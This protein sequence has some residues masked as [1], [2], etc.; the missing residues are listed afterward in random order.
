MQVK[1]IRSSKDTYWYANKIG[2][3]FDVESVGCFSYT[4]LPDCDRSIDKV[5]CVVIEGTD[6]TD[7]EEKS[8]AYVKVIGK[9]Y[10]SYIDSNH[11][12]DWLQD[13][14]DGRRG[15]IY[16]EGEATVVI[17]KL[18]NRMTKCKLPVESVVNGALNHIAMT[19]N[20]NEDEE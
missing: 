10:I 13:R 5:D 18:A 20:L 19:I 8:Y 14:L 2:Y 12:A 6:Y 16:T 9:R 7:E 15:D 11:I 3:V 17:D 4:V 1:I